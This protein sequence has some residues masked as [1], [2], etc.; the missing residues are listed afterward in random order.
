MPN[1]QYLNCLAVIIKHKL[2][3]G[4]ENSIEISKV[5]DKQI[6][7]VGAGPSGVAAATKLVSSGFKNVTILEGGNRYGGRVNTIQFGA[8]VL[9]M[10]AQWFE[11]FSYFTFFI[12]IFVFS[13][14][15]IDIFMFLK[16]IFKE[17]K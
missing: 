2:F 10:G 14:F 17:I 16:F 3:F 5:M 8:N 6:I 1:L 15:K 12:F 11:I 4:C 9:D 7:I 13:V